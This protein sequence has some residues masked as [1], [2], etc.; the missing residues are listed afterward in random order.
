MRNTVHKK[1]TIRPTLTVYNLPTHN[2]NVCDDRLVSFG[3]CRSHSCLSPS[4]CALSRLY[5]SLL[6]VAIPATQAICP[7]LPYSLSPTE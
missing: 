5:T 7:V 6:H 1:Y 4:F 2:F 3:R